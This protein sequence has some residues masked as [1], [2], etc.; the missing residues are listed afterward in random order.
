VV[1][2]LEDRRAPLD[3]SRQLDSDQFAGFSLLSADSASLA[4]VSNRGEDARQLQPGV[5]GLSN[6]ALDTPWHK[7]LRAKAALQ[8]LLDSDEVNRTALM[9]LL[10]DTTPAPTDEV[11]SDDLPFA[12]ART[13][14]APFIVSPDY[15]TRCSSVLLM[16]HD[17]QVEFSERSFAS[18]GEQTGNRSFRYTASAKD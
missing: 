6:A 7:L 14:T 4:S 11:R 3:Y 18:S 13:L 17:G 16:D 1:G 12:L 8:S 9:R 10:R 15:G 2:F 5:Y